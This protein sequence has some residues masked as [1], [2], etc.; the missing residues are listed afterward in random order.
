MRE[1]RALYLFTTSREYTQKVY[2]S[3]ASWANTSGMIFLA[4]YKRGL[5]IFSGFKIYRSHCRETNLLHKNS[6][7]DD[8]PMSMLSH[9][10]NNKNRP[11]HRGSSVKGALQQHPWD[12][13]T[14]HDSRAPWCYAL[15]RPT[16]SKLNPL[17]TACFR[18]KLCCHHLPLPNN[19]CGA[20]H[21]AC[22]Q[23]QIVILLSNF[24]RTKLL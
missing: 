23:T 15:S 4:L 19:D 2:C 20:K 22:I 9:P 17:N 1:S 24:H 18:T 3:Q 8:I 7:S 6:K 16:F 21:E 14:A 5:L 11:R 12:N 10:V 13:R